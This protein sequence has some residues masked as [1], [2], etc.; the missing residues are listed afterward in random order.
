MG[1]C[2]IESCTLSSSSIQCCSWQKK[3]HKIL[4]RNRYRCHETGVKLEYISYRTYYTPA[5]GRIY[6]RGK[7]LQL[8]INQPTAHRQNV[9]FPVPVGIA[10]IGILQLKCKN[11]HF[12]FIY[13]IFPL[14]S[15]P[16]DSSGFINFIQVKGHIKYG[17]LHLVP[18][19]P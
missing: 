8:P 18:K 14:I 13:M 5:S 12:K 10:H 2:L 19:C 1:L 9:P 17:L 11:K 16:C 7:D 3:V 6:L 15:L 4:L